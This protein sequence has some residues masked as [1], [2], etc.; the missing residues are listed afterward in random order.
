[1]GVLDVD[2]DD[3]PGV[4]GSDAQPLA[5]D[6]DDDAAGDF[7]LDADRAGSWRGQRGRGDPGAA[8]LAAVGGRDRAGQGLGQ[9]S[10]T[11]TWIR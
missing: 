1:M 8:Q 9:N 7:A 2:G 6:H 10:V 5:G 3:V 4:G 11:D